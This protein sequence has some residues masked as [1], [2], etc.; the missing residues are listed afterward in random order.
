MNHTIKKVSAFALA[1]T[2]L[3]TGT[4]I[5]NYSGLSTSKHNNVITAFAEGEGEEVY[6]SS[7][8][9][10]LPR[11][12]GKA[13]LYNNNYKLVLMNNGSL[14]IINRNNS[15]IKQTLIDPPFDEPGIKDPRNNKAVTDYLLTLQED[16]NLVVYNNSDKTYSPAI[17]K[18]LYHSNSYDG[19]SKTQKYLRSQLPS[20][21]YR[22]F[23]R[24]GWSRYRLTKKGDL[25]IERYY[26]C[27][28]VKNKTEYKW[29][30]VWDS[31]YDTIDRII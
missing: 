31:R 17:N 23:S 3:G 10:Y 25:V 24:V 15:Q 22:S 18:A 30:T 12:P 6:V 7:E 11:V 13:I 27:V 14:V 29:V 21:A 28:T 4:A 26:K 5:S 16:G 8:E 9:G 1:L 20:T 19:A 2:L